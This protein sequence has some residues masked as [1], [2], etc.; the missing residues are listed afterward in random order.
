M[1]DDGEA[2]TRLDV[3]IEYV[4]PGNKAFEW[5]QREIGSLQGSGSLDALTVLVPNEPAGISV[6]RYLAD[7][8]GCIA[9]KTPRLTEFANE[10]VKPVREG[11]SADLSAILEAAIV[12]RA[13]AESDRTRG[14]SPGAFVSP[15]VT[16]FRDLRRA[17]ITPTVD[18]TASLSSRAAAEV[19]GRFR[20]RAEQFWDLT[21]IV[22]AATRGL[23]ATSRSWP[24][25]L[26]RGV[27]LWLPTRVDPSDAR[28]IGAIAARG[29]PVR[30]ALPW[31]GDALES[32]D[33]ISRAAAALLVE[34][35][36]CALPPEPEPTPGG[37]LPRAPRV[38]RAP[39]PTEEVR[40]VLRAIAEDLHGPEPTPLHSTA[41]LYRQAEP[42]ATLVR[43]ALDAAR[44]PWVSSEGLPLIETRPGR[45]LMTLLAMAR[46]DISLDAIIELLEAQPPPSAALP[47][48]PI[49]RWIG[50]ARM[51]AVERGAALWLDR[52]A[53]L[54]RR[55]SAP[56]DEDDDSER[57][58][59]AREVAQAAARD[60]QRIGEW[61]EAFDADRPGSEEVRPWS[62]WIE[63]FT[64]L[65]DKHLGAAAD[66]AP[67]AS[68]TPTDSSL[69]GPA[70]AANLSPRPPEQPSFLPSPEAR[71]GASSDNIA[72]LI[73]KSIAELAQIARVEPTTTL[74]GFIDALDGA[75]R[76]RS[77]TMGRLGEGVFVGPNAAVAGLRFERVYLLGLV[78]GSFPPTARF[79]PFL[80]PGA[81]GSGGFDRRDLARARERR[82]FLAAMA[83]AP[84]GDV[85]LGVPDAY[86]G[87]A[88]H[89]SRWALEVAGS[90]LPPEQA[91]ALDAEAFRS[92]SHVWLRIVQSPI[93]GT[94]YA[95]APADLE[96]RRR[97]GGARWHASHLDLRDYPVAQREDLPLRRA[98][99]LSRAR[100]NPQVT[101]YDGDLSRVAATARFASDLTRR[102]QS[103]SGLETWATC[104]FR[105]FLQRVLRVQAP[106]TEVS[107][108]RID[109]RV[110]GSIVHGVLERYVRQVLIGGS[111]GNAEVDR[112]VL[113]Q[114]LR[115]AFSEIET[116]FGCAGH[117]LAWLR[118]EDGLAAELAVYLERDA[119][120]RADNAVAPRHVEYRFGR[121][122]DAERD[123][124][125][126]GPI[127]FRG[128][129]D[130]IDVSDDGSK[131][132]VT[133]YK[134]GSAQPYREL[135]DD[136]LLGGEHVQLALYGLAARQ[137][138]P[139]ATD[140]TAAFVFPR[141][142]SGSGRAG[143]LSSDAGLEARFKKVVDAIV[144]GVRAGAFPQ[145]AGEPTDRGGS[146]SYAH[147]ANCDFDRICPARRDRTLRGDDR[148]G[149]FHLALTS[150]PSA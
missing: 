112:A 18:S 30:V 123:P 126:V 53:E 96:D 118:L 85:T 42:Y 50:L 108:W 37:H 136:P 22:N 74:V 10:L 139:G 86:G 60:A 57:A 109:P 27:I 145:V 35:T 138:F 141:S 117:P 44:L 88:A 98:L 120:W 56:P 43:D 107:P 28:L 133:D 81:D 147:C 5:L 102:E 87:R 93:A 46:D 79:D 94:M 134:S 70:T 89:P 36:G 100:I 1:S 69:D 14:V 3:R 83:A 121:F 7:R 131:A 52:M 92:L 26:Q 142:T 8:G 47:D 127:R 29:V 148:I 51:A 34:K 49:A 116:E 149:R 19:F 84:G 129:I 80:P 9:V 6:R 115:D 68:L 76:G 82:D 12:R 17:E 20:A 78:E 135:E 45:A 65:R 150:E 61:V 106:D 41:I 63:W 16:L 2:A 67:A 114:C 105:Y 38:I 66:W 62:A 23:A 11:G 104:P 64:G 91:H 146:R 90:R 132:V 101:I 99:E 122:H 25:L 59:E 40:E 33:A 130:R 143:D 125:V 95:R 103:A 140:V 77:L 110:R 4:R 21:A 55:K 48:L 71:R 75:L 72:A 73:D 54:A 32:G 124:V 128:V 111:G 144:A 58:I 39:D 15:F 113:G 119:E 24:S 137:M 13:I 31:F 97:G